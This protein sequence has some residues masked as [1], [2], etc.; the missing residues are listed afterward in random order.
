MLLYNGLLYNMKK[1]RRINKRKKH[2]RRFRVR[3]R[4]STRKN[5]HKIWIMKGG[6]R[7]SDCINIGL[8]NA[9]RFNNPVITP[10]IYTNLLREYMFGTKLQEDAW[11][12]LLR[13]CS[14][15][16]PVYIL[17]SGNK[18]GVI[19]ML[20]LTVIDRYITEVLCTHPEFPGNPLIP[21]NPLIPDA[22]PTHNFHKKD[23]YEVIK[24]I[25][26][27]LGL[28]TDC[29][30]PIGYFLDDDE[31]NFE[32]SDM[33]PSIH[34]I[35]S[36]GPVPSDFNNGEKLKKN[37]IYKLTVNMLGMNSIDGDDP[38]F[39]FTP[40]ER[41]NQLT[42]DVYSGAVRILFLDFDKTLQIH[43]MA[44]PF[45]QMEVSDI[46]YQN[47]FRINVSAPLPLPL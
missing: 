8:T 33:C 9:Y 36:E 12:G 37:D 15:K 43:N 3:S 44:I 6:L 26:S 27:E 41:I 30:S 46:F 23:K 1:S 14:E 39:N 45:H 38:D 35:L 28:P 18:I 21:V 19:R 29:K 17:T 34:P 5:N 32:S 7:S 20:Q 47:K 11:M 4:T 31:G 25:V 24:A 40:I 2:T 13:E 10:N 16:I 22:P 42:K